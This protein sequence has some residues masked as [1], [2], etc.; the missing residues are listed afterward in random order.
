M[1]PQIIKYKV[2]IDLIYKK[3][4]ADGDKDITKQ[5]VDDLVKYQADLLGVSTKDITNQED[6][7]RL[8]EFAYCQAEA[9][10]LEIDEND[11]IIKTK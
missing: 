8:I 6:F 4:K 5:K 7:Q 2:I 3:L 9:I 10:G 1:Q 11:N